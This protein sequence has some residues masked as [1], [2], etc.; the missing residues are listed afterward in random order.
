MEKHTITQ[1]RS[2]IKDVEERLNE[3]IRLETTASSDYLGMSSWCEVQGHSGA[4]YFLYKQSEEE[5]EHMMRIFRYVQEAG[6]DA[7]VPAVEQPSSRYKSLRNVFEQLLAHE[8]KVSTS[9]NDI[10]SFCLACGDYTT[11]HFL[12]WFL[13]EQ[14]EEEVQAR[15][16]LALFDRFESSPISES[17]IDKELRTLSEK[18]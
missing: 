18:E 2:I 11:H 4:S 14:R 16:A 7:V 12:G 9:I 15:A 8:I 17:L 13:S 3:Q 6:G 1:Q 10:I 5:R